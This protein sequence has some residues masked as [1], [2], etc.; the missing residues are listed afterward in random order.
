MVHKVLEINNE[1]GLRS[2][3]AAL[4]VQV[5]SKYNSQIIIEKG[6]KKIN[7][8]SIMGVLSIGVMPGESIHIVATGEDEKQALAGLCQ[9]VANNF[10]E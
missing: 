10:A 3:S 1:E 6:N 8:K 7:A 5:A 9:L 2:K 4:F